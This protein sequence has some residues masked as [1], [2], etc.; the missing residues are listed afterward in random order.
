MK[1]NTDFILNC[2]NLFSSY[3]ADK[4]TN[5]HICTYIYTHPDALYI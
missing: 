2:E 5:T 3:H 4:K 1:L